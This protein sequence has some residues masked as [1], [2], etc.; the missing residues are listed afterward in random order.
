MENQKCSVTGNGS[1]GKVDLMGEVSVK[2]NNRIFK[3]GCD[4]GEEAHLKLLAD[5][6]GKH[7]ANLRQSVGKTADDQLFL[8]AGLMVCDELWQAREQL[9]E[10][11]ARL[12]QKKAAQT[13]R[14]EEKPKDQCVMVPAAGE[15]QSEETRMVVP[16]G[17]NI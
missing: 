16:V 3:L 13:S 11:T 17:E 15:T 10:T 2:I 14:P 9:L 8:M 4:D 12:Q 1:E 5:H 7:V 6:L